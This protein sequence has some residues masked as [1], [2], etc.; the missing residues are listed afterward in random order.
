MARFL[1][2]DDDSSTVNAMA[3]LLAADG[4]AVTPLTSGADAVE[5]LK[6]NSF[7]AVI[8]DLDMPDVD[9]HDVVRVAH[10]RSPAACVVVATARADDARESLAAA[11]ACIVA[12][13]PLDY[14]AVAGEVTA[15]RA[16]GGPGAHGRCHMRSHVHAPPLVPRRRK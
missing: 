6:E 7:D 8:T 3:L 9:G 11:G 2:V 5:T 4:H 13:K 1:V 14:D 15:C 10:E 12:P 16:R